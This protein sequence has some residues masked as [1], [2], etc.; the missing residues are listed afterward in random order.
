MMMRIGVLGVTSMA[1]TDIVTFQRSTERGH[2]RSMAFDDVIC[3]FSG[4]CV[5]KGNLVR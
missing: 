3:H 1:S 4:F 2:Q 5:P